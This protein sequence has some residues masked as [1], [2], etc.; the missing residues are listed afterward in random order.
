MREKGG[1]PSGPWRL[2]GLEDP[3]AAAKFL[4]PA[5]PR[6]SPAFHTCPPP[7]APAF[8]PAPELRPR[9]LHGST[10]SHCL[11]YLKGLAAYMVKLTWRTSLTLPLSWPE[12]TFTVSPL[13]TCIGTMTGSPF[14][15]TG[16]LFHFF[17]CAREARDRRGEREAAYS[18]TAHLNFLQRV[19][20]VWGAPYH[21]SPGARSRASSLRVEGEG[22]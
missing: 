8:D 21:D 13:R 10:T 18:G 12:I 1:L 22:G 9:Q 17:N 11:A 15:F 14:S 5:A 3:R 4:R 16:V 19:T 7:V 20:Q 6:G 2:Y